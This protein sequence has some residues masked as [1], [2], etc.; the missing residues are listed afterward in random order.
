MPTR[1]PS[2][3]TELFYLSCPSTH[4]PS[5]LRTGRRLCACCRSQCETLL[6]KLPLFEAAIVAAA[7]DDDDGLL[8]ADDDDDCKKKA[9]LLKSL[10]L[11]N[12]WKHGD[13]KPLLGTLV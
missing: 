6:L 4:S 13:S 3:V 2:W 8:L 11:L 7:D 5:I 1:V 12:R 10:L 9:I